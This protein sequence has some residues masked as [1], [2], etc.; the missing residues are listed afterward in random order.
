M[1]VCALTPLCTLWHLYVDHDIIVY[2]VTSLCTLWH[3]CV[4]CVIDKLVLQNGGSDFVWTKDSEERNRLWAARH[5]AFYAA[6]SL[7]PGCKVRH[8]AFCAA[9][10]LQLGCWI[11]LATVYLCSI[12]LCVCLTYSLYSVFPCPSGCLSVSLC[13]YFFICL[14]ISVCQCLNVNVC[15]AM[16]VCQ[17]LPVWLSSMSYVCSCSLL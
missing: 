11:N 16:S 3:H 12:N 2:P 7:R 9:L 4:H 10:S 15:I 6:L 17:C 14:F 1:I 13:Y 5:N 8:N